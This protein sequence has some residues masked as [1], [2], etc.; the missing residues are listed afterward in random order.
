MY[1]IFAFLKIKTG[2]VYSFSRYFC[3]VLAA[4]RRCSTPH[5]S[6][7]SACPC[8]RACACP[9]VCP[10]LSCPVRPCLSVCL[11]VPVC[12]LSSPR[13]PNRP[14]EGG[15]SAS[16]CN[17]RSLVVVRRGPPLGE[18]RGRGLPGAHEPPCRPRSSPR[19]RGNHPGRRGCRCRRPRSTRRPR[20]RPVERPLTAYSGMDGG[21]CK[22][23]RR[24][25][26]RRA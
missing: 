7:P 15:R 11:S 19:A 22:S 18:G 23:R 17:A 16:S 26:S 8:V 3:A 10:V 12:G 1:R 6:V 5:L 4:L 21:W 14:A 9:P 13:R 2:P 20:R 24:H 25:G